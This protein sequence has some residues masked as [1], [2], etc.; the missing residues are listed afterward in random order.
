MRS[1]ANKRC[2]YKW[3][4]YDSAHFFRKAFGFGHRRS[5]R[6][7]KQGI[8]THCLHLLTDFKQARR[9]KF[10]AFTNKNNVGAAQVVEALLHNTG[11]SGCDSRQGR[12]N[13]HSD[14]FFLSASSSP[15]VHSVSNWNECQG[16]SLWAKCGRRLRADSCRP[17]SAE[18]H[19]KD[20]CPTFHVACKSSWLAAGKL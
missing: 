2:R 16:I 5:W 13:L 11:D 20:G 1:V 9:L 19:S 4:T 17:S 8:V 6:V 15:G 18:C 12:L 7:S 14:L 10:I 3:K